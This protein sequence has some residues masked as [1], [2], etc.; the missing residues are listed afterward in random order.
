M[1]QLWLLLLLLMLLLPP[2]SS[3]DTVITVAACLL[4]TVF[5]FLCCTIQF[6]SIH[7]ACVACVFFVTVCCNFPEYPSHLLSCICGCLLHLSRL[8]LSLAAS[9]FVTACVCFTFADCI[10][11]LL[12]ILSPLSA[13]ILQ[14]MLA[15][16]DLF[17][18]LLQ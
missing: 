5:C 1:D 18:H 7:L 3:I 2:A 14:M 15:V 10:L 12:L 17:C 6:C 9:A 16:H 4:L 8:H 11:H 13:V